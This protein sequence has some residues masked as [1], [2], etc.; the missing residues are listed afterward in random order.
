MSLWLF[1]WINPIV[2]RVSLPAKL[3]VQKTTVS[4]AQMTPYSYNPLNR[5]EPVWNPVI[6]LDILTFPA[7]LVS[8]VP[9]NVRPVNTLLITI[10]GV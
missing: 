10:L 2:D 7:T 6:F 3:V 4:A 8:L 9:Y 1:F 5:E